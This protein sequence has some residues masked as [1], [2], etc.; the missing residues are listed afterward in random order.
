MRN[1]SRGSPEQVHLAS[2]DIRQPLVAL[3]DERIEPADDHPAGGCTGSTVGHAPLTTAL[4]AAVA[5]LI[6]ACAIGFVVAYF[7]DT[8][9][10]PDD[11]Q[12]LTGLPTLGVITRM[13]PGRGEEV[14]R[15]ETLRQPRSAVAES[16]R[17]LRT[18]VEFASIDDPIRTLLVTS[19]SE[20]E[21][22]SVTAANLA[23]VFAQ[24][25]RKVL[26]IDA[27]LRRPGIHTLFSASNV[28]GLTTVL[29]GK[30]ETEAVSLPTAQENLSILTTGPLPPNPANSSG[31][32]ECVAW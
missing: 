29:R 30:L 25:G 9:K 13:K 16:Y 20:A 10:S 1:G 14:D 8:L 3:D 2:S 22:K 15:L 12:A 6:G 32:N 17:V 4:L 7:D 5:A 28:N 24:N 19:A 11:V 27:D 21:G 26:L 23:I 18:N 31:R